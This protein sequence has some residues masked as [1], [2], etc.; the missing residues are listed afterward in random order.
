MNVFVEEEV[1]RANAKLM[2]REMTVEDL[3]ELNVDGGEGVSKLEFVE[4]MLKAM[5][6][7]DQ[8]LLDD[9]HMQFEKMDA[10]RSGILNKSDIELTAKTKLALRRKLKLAHQKVGSV[11]TFKK[12]DR[13]PS[14]IVRNIKEAGGRVS[15]IATGSTGVKIE[16]TSLTR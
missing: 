9:L 13:T 11:I 4:F 16:A 7:V 5:H 10:D 8:S 3:D 1:K 15:M 14:E 12:K 2:S 6:K